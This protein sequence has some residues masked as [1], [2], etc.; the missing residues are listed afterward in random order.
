MIATH[1]FYASGWIFPP[2]F[3]INCEIAIAII[4]VFM[5]VEM[6]QLDAKTRRVGEGRGRR[7]RYLRCSW[8]GRSSIGLN[9]CEFLDRYFKMDANSDS[10]IL[11]T[12]TKCTYA[13]IKWFSAHFSCSVLIAK[14]I[15][16]LNANFQ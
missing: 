7:E 9:C 5:F 10:N 13:V 4:Y 12:T 1:S 3:D 8:F 2:S 16:I 15:N 14:K 6:L 11:Q